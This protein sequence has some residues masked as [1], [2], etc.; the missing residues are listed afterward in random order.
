MDIS[1]DGVNQKTLTAT[2]KNILQYLIHAD[3]FDADMKRRV[4]WVIQHKCDQCF[5]QLKK[6]WEPILAE[7]YESIPTDSQAFA[8]LVFDQTDYKDRKQRDAEQDI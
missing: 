3:E 6:D 2:Q 7:R 8:K 4:C 5:E 1:V